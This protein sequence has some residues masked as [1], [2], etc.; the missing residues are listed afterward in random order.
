VA[1]EFALAIIRFLRAPET[2]DAIAAQIQA[3]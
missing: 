1:V 3:P 2:A